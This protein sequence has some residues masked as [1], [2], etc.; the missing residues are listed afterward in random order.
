MSFSFL[1]DAFPNYKAEQPSAT[2][3]NLHENF[4]TISSVTKKSDDSDLRVENFTD[5]NLPV[6]K[7]ANVPEAF[8]ASGVSSDYFK[9]LAADWDSAEAQPTKPPTQLKDAT[10]KTGCMDVANHIDS[11]SECRIRLESIF[12]NLLA[13]P[14]APG[15]AAVVT[16]PKNDSKPYL[17]ITLLIL[18]GIF[19]VFVLDAFVRL[20]RYFTRKR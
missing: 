19:I 14:L 1:T 11:C 18:L 12:R 15:A 8:D 2:H 9:I 5:Y 13:K 6:K 20:G 4:G 17:E 3:A 10:K 16:A 7:H